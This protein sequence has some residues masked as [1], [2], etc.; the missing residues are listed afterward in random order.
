MQ[1][2]IISSSC[3]ATPTKYTHNSFSYFLQHTLSFKLISLISLIFLSV[4]IEA[5]PV[6][7]TLGSIT[8]IP[9]LI[10]FA[11]YAAAAYVKVPLQNWDCGEVCLATQGTQLVKDFSNPQLNTRGYLAKVPEKQLIVVAFRGTVPGS[12]KN[13]ITDFIITHDS[14]ELAPGTLVHRGFLYAWEQIQP[15]VTDDLLKLIREN[16]DY[17]VGFTGHS[18]GAALA[19]FS[20][21][22]A[23]YKAPEL[24]NNEKLFLSTFGQPR[25][26]DEKFA[27]FVDER[28]KAVRTIVRGDPIPRMPPSWPIPFI[29]YYRHFGEEL[30]IVNPDQDPAA[31]IECSAEDPQCSESVP[32]DQLGL[33]YHSGPYY[34]VNMRDANRGNEGDENYDYSA[35]PY[36]NYDPNYNYVG[37]M[38]VNGVDGA[39]RVNGTEEVNATK[40]VNSTKEGKGTKE[41]NG[42]KGV[43]GTEEVN[44]TKVVKGTKGINGAK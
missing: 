22:D 39:K 27:K 15:Q 37:A 20:A 16:P 34:T 36:F 26:G 21:L 31:F 42:T 17:K 19:T 40:E 18:L 33:K 44:G 7:N 1:Q 30:Y 25:V 41:V 29:G 8:S 5:A 35:D 9:N 38:G 43:N 24:A 12:I 11:N 10:S 28:I 23:I 32:L 4:L 2:Q 14:W 3:K 13:Y 6:P